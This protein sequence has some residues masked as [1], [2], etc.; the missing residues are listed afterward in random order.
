MAQRQIIHLDL[1]AFFASVEELL[2]P[3]LK[4]KPVVVGGDP[5]KRG[6]VASA[7]YAARAY[8]V[9]SAMPMREALRL[10]PQ[11]IV[12]RPRHLIYRRFSHRVMTLLAEYTPLVEPLS[13]DEAFLDLTESQARWGP[14]ADIARQIQRRIKEEIGLSASLGVA[15]N[16]LVAK[17]ASDQ[18][19]PGGLVV[20]P[21]GQEAAFL[22]PLPVEKLW[23]VG[24]VTARRLH[25][26]GVTTIGDLARLPL[27]QLRG[28]LG[29]HGV[30]LYQHARGVDHSPVEPHRR[31][32]SISQEHTFP[33][34]VND[35]RELLQ[36]LLRLSQGVAG[37]L[38]HHGQRARTI[39][40]KLRRADF[41]TVTRSRTLPAPTDSE[42]TI[43]GTVSQL[44][45]KEWRPRERVRLLGVRAS[46]FAPQEGY[47]LGLFS[48][49]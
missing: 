1:D 25:A 12:R 19:K 10:C 31:R 39:T 23:G 9:H 26:L 27:A 46:N 29:S 20:V 13:I 28:E 7:S 38:R 47:Q 33:R 37:A 32:K 49:Q 6:V 3:S 14:A 34:D 45:E 11:A 44:F 35:R 15:S 30:S 2:D 41:S 48:S 4:G 36:E 5:D 21:P 16:K 18:G 24:K 42:Q 17:I 8:G 22:A 40:L 43:Y